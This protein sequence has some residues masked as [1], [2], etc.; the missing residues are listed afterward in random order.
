MNLW[1]K[2]CKTAEAHSFHIKQFLACRGRLDKYWDYYTLEQ[3]LYLYRNV[4]S[5]KHNVGQQ[6]TLLEL[7][8]HLLSRRYIPIADYTMNQLTVFDQSLYP[9]YHFRKRSINGMYNMPRKDTFTLAEILKREA[10]LAPANAVVSVEEY[11]EIDLAFKTSISGVVQTKDLESSLID[12]TDAVPYKLTDVLLNHWL[13]FI[14]QD[15]YPVIVNF[16]DPITGE[17]RSLSSRA[18]YI[19]LVYLT[20]Q[21]YGTPMP[22]YP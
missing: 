13:Y 9:D 4:D 18:A 1:L 16:R 15:R 5:L 20:Y 22:H 8:E 19:Y 12:Y 11:S 21:Q 7:I 6:T 2:R 14:S 3:A 10:K 17:Q